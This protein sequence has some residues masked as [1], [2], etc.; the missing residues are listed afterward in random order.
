MKFGLTH[1]NMG[2]TSDPDTAWEMA[3][4]AEAAGFESLWTVDHA[5]I[6]TVYE[7]VYPETPDGHF[8]FPLDHPLADPLPWL[9][10][11]GAATSR[12]K[13][14]TAILVLPQRNVVVTAKEAAT[15][16]RLTGGR[17]LLGVGAGWCREEFEAVGADFDSRGRRLREAVPALRALWTGRPATYESD[18]VSFTGVITQPR[19]AGPTIPIHLGG[20]GTTAAARAGRIGDGFF[21]A[22]YGDLERLE[23]LIGRARSAAAAAGRD[24]SEVEITTRWTRDPADV[25]IDVVHRLEELGVDRVTVPVFL[26]DADYLIEEIQRFGERYVLP[27][28]S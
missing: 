19:P 9:T 8:P 7:K 16:D 3:R 14:G 4:A 21:P 26:F 10:W 28:R 11:V 13:L 6:P 5:I 20:F 23:M 18:S 12:V 15:V 25:D 22:G 1:G 17:L 24:P 27:Y 2:R